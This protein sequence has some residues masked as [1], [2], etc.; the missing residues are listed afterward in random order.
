MDFISRM[1]KKELDGYYI[2]GKGNIFEL[3]KD[4]DGNVSQKKMKNTDFIIT[5]KR[6][7]KNDKCCSPSRHAYR[8]WYDSL[9]DPRTGQPWSWE[10]EE[11]DYGMLG[12]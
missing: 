2:D 4:E 9:Q 10:M 7:I 11:Y 5:E 1:K 12:T 3:Y 8:V 6:S